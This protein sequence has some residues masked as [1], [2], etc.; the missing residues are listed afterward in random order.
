MALSTTSPVTVVPRGYER[1]TRYYNEISESSE[2]ALELV[3]A[4]YLPVVGV[5]NKA[6]Y[7]YVMRAGTIVAN[8]TMT[9]QGMY[10]TFANGG[11]AATITYTALDVYDST[12]T[13]T[14][15]VEDIGNLGSL[16]T[17]AGA[18]A[19][20]DA[21]NYPI[22]YAVNAVYSDAARQYYR[23]FQLQDKITI[24]CDKF[25]EIPVNTSDQKTGARALASG[26]LVVPMPGAL[27]VSVIYNAGDSIEQVI[28]RVIRVETLSARGGLDKVFTTKDLTLPGVDT[29]GLQSHVYH[30]GVTSSAKINVTLA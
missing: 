12:D 30:S 27:G 15:P 28:G 18:S 29:G 3:P 26:H 19:T 11:T 2:P 23:N 20:Q 4:H 6:N 9:G 24:T 7:P 17:G 1:R 25:I 10:L 22:G 21:L 13:S 14:Y 8:S 5:N 16:V